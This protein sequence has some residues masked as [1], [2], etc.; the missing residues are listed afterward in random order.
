MTI[1]GTDFCIQQKCAAS[2]GNLFGCHKFAGKSALRYKLRGD[3]AGNSV[4]VKGPYPTGAWND[5][6]IFNSVLSHCLEPGECVE[7]NN[8][9]VGHADKI[10]CPNN[11]CNL[12]ENLGMQGT[13]RSC[14]KRLNGCLEN[15]VIL[16][17]VYHHN[18]TVH[19]TVFFACVVITQ[20]TIANGKP[21][22][23]VEYGDE[24]S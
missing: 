4:W 16:E 2:K 6:K 7:A 23:K 12:V 13:A 19:G 17:K 8:G 10:K 5:I 21:L 11:D 14:H 1:N 24:Q 22:F 15:W 3:I 20:L 9:Y 18:I